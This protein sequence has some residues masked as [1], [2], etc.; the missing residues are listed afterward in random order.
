MTSLV[1]RHAAVLFLSFPWVGTCEIELSQMG[2][3]SGNSVQVC[4]NNVNSCQYIY[5][6]SKLLVTFSA[7]FSSPIS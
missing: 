7:S 3:N 4:K 2:K 6:Q 5:E 1:F